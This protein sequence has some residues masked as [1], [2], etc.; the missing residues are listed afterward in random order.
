MQKGFEPLLPG[1][2]R[3][4]LNDIEAL[5]KATDGHPDVVAVFFETIQGEGGVNPARA[6]YPDL[7]NTSN[8]SDN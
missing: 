1:F 7:S 2:I 4:P 8:P 5:K 6:H 3:V